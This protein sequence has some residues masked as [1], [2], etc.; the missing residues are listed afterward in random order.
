MSKARRDGRSETGENVKHLFASSI[1]S[2]LEC[3]GYCDR[4]LYSTIIIHDNIIDSCDKMNA[5]GLH[6]LDQDRTKI[7][8]R[9][10]EYTGIIHRC[11]GHARKASRRQWEQTLGLVRRT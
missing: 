2:S 1:K 5:D 4:L 9:S 3:S 11:D 10:D 7:G 8:P 6:V